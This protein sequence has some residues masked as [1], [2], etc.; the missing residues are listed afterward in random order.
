MG[1]EECGVLRVTCI[2]IYS[3]VALNLFKV[4]GRDIRKASH[5][6]AVSVIFYTTLLL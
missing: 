1:S 6:E 3:L 4:N 2:L 5:D